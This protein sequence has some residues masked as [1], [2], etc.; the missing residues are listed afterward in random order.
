MAELAFKVPIR[1]DLHPTR[2]QAAA[3][4]KYLKHLPHAAKLALINP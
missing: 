3:R 1:E 4:G 2:A